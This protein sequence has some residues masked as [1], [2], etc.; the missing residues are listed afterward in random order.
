MS[1]M[2]TIPIQGT[3]DIALGRRTLREKVLA[4]GWKPSFNA[5]A[6]AALT[7]LGELILLASGGKSVPVTL[8]LVED[9]D[10]AGIQ[11]SCQVNPTDVIADSLD[12]A[13]ERLDQAT[14]DLQIEKT[15]RGFRIMAQV[16]C[17]ES[18]YY[19]SHSRI[20]S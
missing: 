3:F 20:V 12:Q 6:A 18:K 8:R 15:A 14:D 17:Y 9:A 11:L 19:E 2:T 5:R 4:Q 7:A 10:D 13:T 16:R 1:D